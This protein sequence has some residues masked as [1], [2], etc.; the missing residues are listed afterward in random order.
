MSN[1]TATDPW[2]HY[3]VTYTVAD[4]TI[5][6]YK[7]GALNSSRVPA[8]PLTIGTN[9]L[10]LG[11]GAQLTGTV[12]PPTPASYFTGSL[13]DIRLYNR[14]LSSVEI[15]TL[16]NASSTTAPTVTSPTVSAI[17]TTGATL[18]ANVTSDG[19]AAI[20]ARGTCWGVAPAPITNCSTVAGTT[21]V[22]TGPS[23]GTMTAGTLIYYRGYATN[24][25]GTSYSTDDSFTTTA[26]YTVGGTVSGLSGSGLVLQNNG[27]DNKAISGNGAFVFTTPVA[28]TATYA[29]TVLTQP[30]T[31]EQT[32][33]VTN[34]TGP[35]S[36]A[37]VTDVTVNCT[38]NTYTISGTIVDGLSAPLPNVSV[39][40]SGNP[41]PTTTD[42]SGNYIF[43]G[44]APGSYLLTPTL[45]PYTFDPTYRSVDINAIT[46]ADVSGVNFTGYTGA[47]PR[48]IAV[49][50]QNVIAGTNATVPITMQSLG[51]ENTVAFSLTWNPAYLTGATIAPGTDC[52]DCTI[53]PN[54]SSGQLGV[55][56]SRPLNTPPISPTFTVGNQELI[57]ITF[58][59]AGISPPAGSAV[60]F[61]NT[62]TTRQ[63]IDANADPLYASYTDGAV[64]FG[65]D[66][67]ATVTNTPS[68][69]NG[70]P[71]SA[72]VSCSG[73]G[74]AN[75]II[76]GGAATQ[77]NVGT[78]AVFANCPAAPGYN[79]GTGLNAG[80]FA[81]APAAV[82]VTA[83]SPADISYG[84]AAP[85]VTPSYS[86]FVSPDTAP[87]TAPTC[88]TSY[89][90]G[91][92]VGAY[93]T[94]CS[95]AA[96]PNYTFT[97][98]D[99][100]FNVTA[101]AVTVTASSPADISYG[102]AAP[103]V[104]PSYSG[105]VLPDTA[106]ATPPTCGTL[107]TAG[108]PVGPYTTTCSGAA[109]PNYTFTYT[110]G[111]FN[112]TAAVVTVTAS[113]PADIS[114]GSVAPVVTPSYSGFVSPD[115]A[116]VTAPT[117]GTSYTAG[118]AVGAYATTCSGAASPNYTFT[119]TAGS[120][121]VTAAVVTVTASS[122]ADI[123]YGSAAPV[124][125]PSYSGFVL[126]DTAPATPPTC[127]TLY[128][129]GN[130][131][132]PYTTTC[133]GA[134]SPNYTF[135]Y[136]AGSFNV[137][138][139]VVTVTTS[140][141]A[142]ISYGSAAPSV[143]PS[144]SGFVS[145]DTA[146][147][148][149]P[150]CG[151]SYTAG[152]AV[153]A[154]ATTCSG[155][156]SPNYTFTY[157]AGSFNVTAAVVT[158]TASSPAD[159][160]Y[161]SAAPVVTPSY[162]GFV[163]PDTAP[164]TPPT[165]GTLYTAGNPVGP[166][167]T[168]C[169]G[170]ASPNYTFTYTAGSFNV[171]NA[172]QTAVVT[173]SPQVFDGNVKTATVVCSAG[174]AVS[175]IKYDG[176][177]TAPSA[178][179]LYDITADCA[180]VTNYDA[181][182]DLSAG[183]FIIIGSTTVTLGDTGW[184]YYDEILSVD[185]AGHDFVVGPGTP[186]SGVGSAR[187]VTNTD[188]VPGSPYDPGSLK[189]LYTSQ[190]GGVRLDKITSL[191][192]STYV[193]STAPEANNYPALQF[194]V[195]F[196]LT[197]VSNAW[198]GRVNY[199][200]NLPGNLNGVVQVH[201]WQEWDAYAGYFWYSSPGLVPSGT[202]C[203]IAAPCTI[204][205]M[206]ADHPNMGIHR[207]LDPADASNAG[208]AFMGF[209]VQP[210]A[211]A[212]VDKF[213][214]SVD[215]DMLAPTPTTDG[216]VF[217]FEPGTLVATIVADN[218]AYDGNTAAA[219]S[220][221]V[222]TGIVAPDTDVQCSATGG[223]FANPNVANGIAVTANITLTGTD[224]DNYTVNATATDTADITPALVTATAGSG[225]GV[226]TGAT[227]SPTACAVSGAYI[228]G[229]SCVNNPASVGPGV[230]TTVIAPVTSGADLPNFTV[231]PVNGSYEI[232]PADL[233]IT[234]NSSSKT[235]G[236]TL[237]F[238]GTEFTTTG[239]VSPDTVTSVTLTSAGAAAVAAVGPYPIVA[240]AA[241]GTGLGNYN[242]SYVDGVL[243]VDLAPQTATIT[244]TPQVFTG[245]PQTATVVCSGGGAATLTG[246]TGT[247]AGSYP[248]TVDCAAS[249]NYA[250][251]NGLNAGNFVIVG[252]TTI[253]YGATGQWTYYDEVANDELTTYDFTYPPA[254]APLGLGSARLT[255]TAGGA[256]SNKS[257]YT[258]QF[259]GTKLADITALRYSTYAAGAS[260][261]ASLQFNV[262]FDVTDN[263]HLWQGRVNY[264]PSMNGTVTPNTWQEW[265]AFTG[266][267]WY[268]SGSVPPGNTNQ[269]CTIANGGCTIAE[270]LADHPNMGVHAALNP[271]GV[272]A[273]P[274]YAFFGFYAVEN[275]NANV[276]KFVIGTV[277]SNL[278]FDFEPGTSTVTLTCPA[279]VTYNGS[280]QTPCTAQAAGV[281]M[282]TI[283]FTGSILYGANTN[284]GSA[285]ASVI[286]PGSDTHSGDS[287]SGG[288]TINPADLTI[289]ANSSSKTYGATLTF[290]GT[291]FTTTGLVSPDT[292]TSVT[293]TSAGAAAVAA[294]GPY[295][296]V[297]N[298]VVGTGL[299]NYNISYLDGV[300][301]VD[302]APQTA[303]IT[304]TPQVFTGSPQ[305]ATVV[306][307]GGGTATLTGGTG[308]AAGSYPAT[309]DCAASG[310]YA[311]TNG[312]N[313]G[314]FVIVGST[315][316]TYGA[317]G[318]WTYY[319]EVAN[320]ELTTYDFTYPPAGAPLG[321]GSARLTTTAGGAGSNKSIYTP[322]F[323]GTKLADIT[324]LRYST[325][326][327]GASAPASLQFNVDFDVTDNSHLWQG[328]VNY[329]PS[330]NGTVTPNTWQEWNAFTG[331][332]WYSSGSVPP[333][334][335][336]QA[337]TIANGGCTIAE[338]LVDHP[339][340]GVHA[341][342]NP[343]GVTADPG[344]AFFG[345]YA[346]EDSNANV[347]KFVIGTVSSNL[348]FDFE[349]G[350]STVTLT[351][352]VS[353]T[354]NGSA[355]TPCTAQAAGVGM[356]TI[357]LT[358]SILYGANTNAGSATASVIWPGSDTHSGDSD[359]GG[360][361]INP[362]DLTI[363]ANSSSK[364]YGATLTFAGTEFTT[365]GLVSPD[366][367]TSVTLT[368][369]GAAAVA[370]VGPY[371]IVANAAVGT[372]L[373][374]YNISYVDGVLTVDLA[375]QTAT[376]TN[377]PQV[378]TGS[379][380][381]A[382]VVCSGGG[383]ATLT[384]GTGTAAGSYPATVDCAASGNYAATNGLNAGNF[385]IVG[386][387]TITYG[388][389]G[390]WTYYDEVAND[391][392]T[393]YDFTY[394]PAGAP[395]GLGSARLTT[396]AGGAG[397]N[398]SI[399]T[400]QF[401]GTKL[402][403]ITALRYSTY[404][405]G[406][407]APASLQFNVDFDVTDNSHLWQ[408]RVNYV[409][410]MN[411]TVTPNTWQEWNAFTGKF[412]YS[413]GSVPPGNTNQACT[414][415]NGGCTIA[416]M[417][418][419]HPNMGVHA[420]LNPDGVTA[421]PGYAF[422]GFYAVEDSNANV[423]KFVIG[424]V[425]SNL[426]FDFEPG[427]STVTLT[428]PVSVTYNGSAQTPCTAQ[429]A[430]V[431]MTTIDLTGSILYGANTNA[432]SATAS[433][434]WP[435]SDT[436]SGDS[437]S[438]GFTIN[439]ADLTITANSSSKTYGATLTFAGTEFTTTGLVSPDTVTSVTLTSAG[440]AAVAA[441]GPYPIVANA[442]V[443]TGLGNYNISYVDG[444]LTVDPAPQTATITNTPQV[445]T[446][447]PQTA[448][449]VCS[450]GGAA[451]LTGGT[452]TAAGSYPATVDCAANGNYAE[453][454]NVNAGTFIIIG[455]TT[456]T[457]GDTGWKYYDEILSVDIAGHDFVVG[458]GT[459][460]SGVGSARL[461]TNTDAVPGSPYDPGSLKALYT[462]QFGGVR[463]DKI[464][465]LR[466]STYVDS[467]APE[468]NNYP[469]LQFNVDFDLTDVSNAWQGRVNYSPN[470][471]GNVNGV[472]QVDTWQEWDAYAGYFWYSS[473]G[474]VPSGTICTIAAPCTIAQMLADHPNMG[475][476]RPLDPADASNA[477]YAFM[478]FRVQPGAN[479]NV[480]K[481]VISV[482]DDISCTNTDHGW[483]CVQ[484]RAGHAGSDD[485]C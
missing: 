279:S 298:A 4:N 299:G 90:A 146:P 350:T 390:Q 127:G 323:A 461:V 291:E 48:L 140:S 145:P 240:N 198:Q 450:G 107:Y 53:T 180:A 456:V 171:I 78:Y 219:I 208:Y 206:L 41:T 443:G 75:N 218:K 1:Y 12:D 336:N 315:T 250:A 81:I 389:T 275:S 232:N 484:L 342:L 397:S 230:G 415:A 316:I 87:V 156:A 112:V 122:P 236:A 326:A 423:D 158:V 189:A 51:N 84:S 252:S 334:N 400:P 407:S 3:A 123:S 343:D 34:G 186:P 128:T 305:T 103:V 395:L 28:D 149:A 401:A 192:Y 72:S 248:A 202:I 212:N 333:G 471:P 274:G 322:Q 238:A 258:P 203:T 170:A 8:S 153:G 21:G 101:A 184:K 392:L 296:I 58:T 308:T 396:T 44:L 117:C 358:G 191:R 187:L 200:P 466:Y 86:G 431:G 74:T 272:T 97:Y 277:S 179:G 468:A 65:I 348:A 385:V 205:Q 485:R 282:S 111:S 37:N 331:K 442:A 129:A 361:T 307:S 6:L 217:N 70:T 32:C 22:F 109:S 73:G 380:Q 340:M 416:E 19:G 433:V 418:V 235:Y 475:I 406:A 464:T 453:T 267:F 257:I 377:T 253:T 17:S 476:H 18:G 2:T 412:W 383:A 36:G 362:A 56:I 429:A 314:N 204:A 141:P 302:P 148:T 463:L 165:C 216:I 60:T 116:P 152:N 209:R 379:P 174:G 449:V 384:G 52:A 221:C 228:G 365:T 438:G 67:I 268:S 465:S 388:A 108:N 222:L 262:D 104:T 131:V 138:A 318:Q 304:N 100:S 241:V 92:A 467:T 284:A 246:G 310:N 424:T 79:P 346:V 121:N 386:S 404:A 167:T 80:S 46:P 178:V 409:P 63:V 157:T 213:V 13:D 207:P 197:D 373:G 391:E 269:A 35:I 25:V 237:T 161:G 419:D 249:G 115:T 300:L 68:M 193:D 472:V 113:S 147:V 410:S 110:A 162:S 374:N 311:A 359:S 436:H 482:D 49:G 124:V 259:A 319:D 437:H 264:V 260:A 215:D 9:A 155:A 402:A 387:T 405:A 473:P 455:S 134:A 223:L 408:G 54:I 7:D 164:A 55:I 181:G 120:F 440:A 325:Y 94:T 313:A 26:T 99:G 261:P 353:V 477:G 351:C 11:F 460:P 31:P 483:H 295:S 172:T 347:D 452:G 42:G 118:N 177:P 173:N 45:A 451:T 93:A 335:T 24:S 255:T 357:D 446:G 457:L 263:S 114:Y 199:S 5:R 61:G 480:D 474:L 163:L 64:T 287:D 224:A 403:D 286:W 341:A 328:R 398:K 59:T 214:I 188:A 278:A 332:F 83:S 447:S 280:A 244:N 370:A 43:T 15:L 330:M 185:I 194:N 98:T 290:A 366:T 82:T 469:A 448:T 371:S 139:A 71:Q 125:T 375:P 439:P 320:D 266:K 337:C 381:T 130:P 292:V 10:F 422:F 23:A 105:F 369:A 394:P 312:L 354:Y 293:L 430:G 144:Y 428:C 226:Y 427:T 151:T 459:P 454:L 445:F 271:D 40:I 303:T 378:F 413:S 85:S 183:T 39:S 462:S 159:I 233:T 89:T 142:D 62:P 47:S 133:S 201:T 297:A 327:A 77:T 345:F 294:V 247:A 356:T 175:D 321:L 14:A 16:A 283:D 256:G 154:Y 150:T 91:N 132:G 372:G 481:F 30:G 276:D 368:S 417:L 234:A 441:V 160:S 470:L 245:S 317:T 195:D 352:P 411:G 239:L 143:T 176:S 273:D 270:M 102:S 289:T 364:T 420:A 66:Q 119:Y 88:G 196:D 211:N 33:L 229:L 27:G 225:T 38:T 126:P 432:G 251:T 137:T 254:G 281:G 306:C 339:N 382:T 434:I 50:S 136:T 324:A 227:Q 435:G 76:T 414:I 309:V 338:M 426:A 168:T 242:I 220:S 363:T 106:P 458:P 478:G 360:F 421:D 355:Q 57:K 367:V 210:G 29:V 231:T 479:A 329:V 243:T 393:T 190:F 166:Y 285:T 444:V 301:T 265:N 288:F 96:S 399:Y 376:I 182:D 135:T 349:P 425:S 169:S 69:Y 20:T 344:Y 95:G